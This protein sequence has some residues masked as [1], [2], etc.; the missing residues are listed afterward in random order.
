MTSPAPTE[1]GLRRVIGARGLAAAI[2]NITVGAA[3]FVLPAHMAA[4]LGAA[5]PLAYLVCALATALAALC[6]AQARSRRP[7]TGGPYAYVGTAVGP[8][9]PTSCGTP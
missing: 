5:A 8:S 4:G 1:P 7:R 6:M 9:A 3:I 2:F